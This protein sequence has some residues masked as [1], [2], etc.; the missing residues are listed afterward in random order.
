MIIK[1]FLIIVHS[2]KVTVKTICCESSSKVAK[3]I[4]ACIGQ[5]TKEARE[6]E[7]NICA[8]YS[9]IGTHWKKVDKTAR[10]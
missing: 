3:S 8:V 1:I 10:F 5:Y 4:H 9:I 7:D 6:L 2:V